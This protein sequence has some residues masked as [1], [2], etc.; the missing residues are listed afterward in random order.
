M[1]A[2]PHDYPFFACLSPSDPELRSGPNYPSEHNSVHRAGTRGYS[3]NRAAKQEKNPLNP[4]WLKTWRTTTTPTS[5]T[6]PLP[7]FQA[8]R[9]AKAIYTSLLNG[10]YFELRSGASGLRQRRNQDKANRPLQPRRTSNRD[11]S[12]GKP[13]IDPVNY[14]TLLR[15]INRWKQGDQLKNWYKYTI[16]VFDIPNI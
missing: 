2:T 3:K 8:C 5:V 1:T 15:T 9:E 10:T 7:H 11:H 14:L 16:G 12:F 6:Q 4:R 13:G